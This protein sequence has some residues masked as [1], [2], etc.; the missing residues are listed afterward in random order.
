MYVSMKKAAELASVHYR[1]IMRY[2]KEG[3][4]IVVV[5]DAILVD[6]EDVLAFKRFHALRTPTLVRQR[7]RLVREGVADVAIPDSVAKQIRT[8]YVKAGGRL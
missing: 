7:Q 2:R 5:D 3:L 6:V 4:R 1:T 8:A